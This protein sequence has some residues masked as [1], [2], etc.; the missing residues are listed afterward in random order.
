MRLT[1]KVIY[2]STYHHVY[3]SYCYTM[4]YYIPNLVY[5]CILYIYIKGIL[6]CILYNW[7]NSNLTLLTCIYTHTPIYTY[8]G[9]ILTRLAAVP[10]QLGS[11]AVKVPQYVLESETHFHEV[12]CIMYSCSVCCLYVHV[13]CLCHCSLYTVWWYKL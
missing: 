11:Q 10:D 8:V 13:L 12:Q 6:T 3:M 7:P 1:L 5:Y 2:T 4:L 9:G